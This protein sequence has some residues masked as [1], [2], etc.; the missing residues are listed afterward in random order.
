VVT[1]SPALEKEQAQAQAQTEALAQHEVSG[2][3]QGESEDANAIEG[4]QDKKG[5]KE[6]A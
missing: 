1:P 2:A 6:V 4:Q 3:Q 5:W